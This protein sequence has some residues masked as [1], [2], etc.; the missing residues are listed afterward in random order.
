MTELNPQLRHCLETGT[1]YVADDCRGRMHIGSF[2]RM[3]RMGIPAVCWLTYD[4]E[5]DV[6]WNRWQ[7]FDLIRLN[8]IHPTWIR[9]EDLYEL[10]GNDIPQIM[11]GYPPE[12]AD[13]PGRD[14]HREHRRRSRAFRQGHTEGP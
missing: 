12:R 13:D 10:Y 1:D 14:Q 6:Y 3:Y 7:I 5:K 4:G 2:V 8:N 11:R 9:K